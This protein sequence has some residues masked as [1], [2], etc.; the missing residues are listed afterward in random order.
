MAQ[1]D[2][3]S[4]F[5][6]KIV[7]GGISVLIAEFFL[8]GIHIDSWI[9]GFLLAAILI[10]I[11]LTIKPLMIVLTL[12]LTLITFGLFLLVIN[13]LVIMLA[14]KIIP[15]FQVDGFWWAL[16]FAIVL[17]IINSLFGN[18]LNSN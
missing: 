5:L 9:T 14:D 16:L 18:N 6:V 17:S 11:N 13:A 2:K 3:A 10:L 1:Q 4:S 12:P 7:L 15:G 8:S